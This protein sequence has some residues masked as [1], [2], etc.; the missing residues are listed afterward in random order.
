MGLNGLITAPC[1]PIIGLIGVSIVSDF[2]FGPPDN[3]NINALL[4]TGRLTKKTKIGFRAQKFRFYGPSENSGGTVCPAL[5]VIY[6]QVP[7][8]AQRL[9]CKFTLPA[10]SPN[11]CRNSSSRVAVVPCRSGPISMFPSYPQLVTLNVHSFT[12]PQ[13]ARI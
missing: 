4:E 1:G 6:V 8:V 12:P 3:R 2:F 5:I 10:T 11:G 9:F 7:Y 13:R